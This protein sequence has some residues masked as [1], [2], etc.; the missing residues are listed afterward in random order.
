MDPKVQELID[1]AKITANKAAEVASKAAKTVGKKTEEAVK[2][3][4]SSLKVF[5][6]NTEIEV[7]YKEMGELLYKTHTGEEVG[8]DEIDNRLALIDAKNEQIAALKEEA[9]S[10]KAATQCPACGQTVGKD[11]AFCRN[12]GEKL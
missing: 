11:D 8:E 9:A 1:K 3:T 12:C 6:L 4:K 5:D 2:S 7:L 10:R